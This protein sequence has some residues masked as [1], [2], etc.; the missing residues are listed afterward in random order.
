MPREDSP[1]GGDRKVSSI[2][3]DMYMISKAGGESMESYFAAAAKL[4][5]EQLKDHIRTRSLAFARLWYAKDT[6]NDEE[7]YSTVQDPYGNVIVTGPSPS[8]AVKLQSR[9]FERIHAEHEASADPKERIDGVID[10]LLK[11][12]KTKV[13]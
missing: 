8:Q 2:L 5:P 10:D 3:R 13:W 12:L 11:E 4:K 7:L 9:A 1:T 6:M